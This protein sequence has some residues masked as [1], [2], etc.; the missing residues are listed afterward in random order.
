MTDDN[1]NTERAGVNTKILAE[2]FIGGQDSFGQNIRVGTRSDADLASHYP[3]SPE[4]H[5]LSVDGNRQF[6]QYDG[7]P[8]QFT[9]IGDGFELAPQAD[10][11]VVTLK[12]AE[13][14][15]YTVQFVVKWSIAFK[16]NQSLQSGDAW[17]VGFGNP[18]LENSTDDTPGPNA[19]GWFVYQNNTNNP[20]EA[21]LAEYR[22]GLSVDE[23][24]VSFSEL[25]ESWGRLAGETN[26][27][28]V[29][30]T[31]LIETFVEKE[32]GDTEQRNSEI[33][34][35]G[36]GEGKGPETANK[37]LYAS[38]KA[39]DGAGSLTFEAGSMGIQTLGN[40]TPIVRPKSFKFD[41]DYTLTSGEYEPLA[42]VRV[43]PDRSEVTSEV[44][45]LKP[46]E[47]SA[48]NSVELLLQVFDESNVLDGS[49]NTLTDSDYTT[50]EPLS[51][52]NSTL[53]FSTA[54]EQVVDRD[55]ATQTSVVKPGGYQVGAG[56]LST[57][58]GEFAQTQSQTEKRL[59]PDRDIAVIMAKSDATGTVTGDFQWKEQW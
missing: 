30:E 49:G 40:I 3:Y 25:P 35:V 29:G 32:N 27:Y 7:E 13:R 51:P 45:N 38:V 37:Q 18:D 57:S 6:I 8:T 59:I 21:T 36:I 28:N 14:F 34:T 33:G 22:G 11:E 31:N 43:D 12:T 48:D 9:D 44:I 19:D 26:W 41:L 5:R 16:I 20:D 54:V 10:G 23:T 53:E 52:T 56:F 2:R 55:G 4:R 24:I 58:G 15:R 17:V 1:L 46:L 39:G 50:P 47:F 42:A